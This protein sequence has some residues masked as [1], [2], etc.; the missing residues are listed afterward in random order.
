MRR[1]GGI[2]GSTCG[3][4]PPFPC[5]PW[6]PL[7]GIPPPGGWPRGGAAGLRGAREPLRWCLSPG[8]R[9]EPDR[10]AD[11]LRWA[12]RGPSEDEWSPPQW[13]LPHQVDAARRIAGR[14]KVFRGALLAD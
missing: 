2:A 14:L 7:P 3:S 8:E 11:V 10:V 12:F 4:P 9:V 5:R 13:V 6:E 1:A